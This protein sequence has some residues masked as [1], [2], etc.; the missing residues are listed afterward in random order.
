MNGHDT[1]FDSVAWDDQ[2]KQFDENGDETKE[3]NQMTIGNPM[4]EYSPQDELDRVSNRESYDAF[5]G[6]NYFPADDE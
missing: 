3:E 6:I 5:R 2:D 1:Y 4:I